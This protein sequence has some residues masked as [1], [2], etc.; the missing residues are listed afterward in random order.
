MSDLPDDAGN[1]DV[2]PTSGYTF[3]AKVSKRT[4][5]SYGGSQTR[6]PKGHLAR[7]DSATGVKVMKNSGSGR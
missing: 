5:N 2:T 3:E 7:R 6:L 4:S 1:F